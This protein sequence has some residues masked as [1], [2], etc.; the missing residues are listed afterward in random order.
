MFLNK[1]LKNSQSQWSILKT[2]IKLSNRDID[3]QYIQYQLNEI[4]GEYDL[5]RNLRDFLCLNLLLAEGDFEP[6]LKPMIKETYNALGIK[7]RDEIIEKYGEWLHQ[8]TNGK[9]LLEWTRYEDDKESTWAWSLVEHGSIESGGNEIDIKPLAAKN[10]MKLARE[11]YGKLSKDDREVFMSFQD[12]LTFSPDAQTWREYLSEDFREFIARKYTDYVFKQWRAFWGARLDEPTVDV[13]N[14]IERLKTVPMNELAGVIS[15][16]LNV[17]HVHGLMYEKLDLSQSDLDYMDN[18]PQSDVQA[19]KKKILGDAYANVAVASIRLSKPKRRTEI[20]E[21]DSGPIYDSGFISPDGIPYDISEFGR[22]GDWAAIHRNWLESKGF[23]IG[24]HDDYNPDFDSMGGSQSDS[25][26]DDLVRQGW[27]HIFT[28]EILSVWKYDFKTQ[29]RIKRAYREHDINSDSNVIKIIEQS[30]DSSHTLNLSEL[31]ENI[32]ASR[33]F[34]IREAYQNTKFWFDPSGKL[35]SWPI[36]GDSK[37]A[38]PHHQDKII[39]LAPELID[40]EDFTGASI[41]K[42]G[43]VYDRAEWDGWVAGGNIGGELFIRCNINKAL[44]LIRSLP[45]EL[46]QANYVT[47]EDGY[48]DTGSFPTHG[49]DAALTLTREI[50]DN[51]DKYYTTANYIPNPKTTMPQPIKRN[52]DY[53]E[54]HNWQDRVKWH[55]KKQKK[56]KATIDNIIQTYKGLTK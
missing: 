52:F 9:H 50:R 45:K 38:G 1:N 39:E 6:S 34:S 53:N 14:S 22:H 47:V 35:Y 36:Q 29:E 54:I 51:P 30:N 44:E 8:H 2:M 31:E 10:L 43:K 48:A 27:I 42:K 23:T 55:Q 28:P 17:A 16:A 21:P 56:R 37:W 32:F 5:S 13:Q 7:V 25:I 11:F 19:L 46:R 33:K 12:E 4:L 18:I 40:G 49:Q 26:R 41:E 24:L 15:M 3:I 20:V